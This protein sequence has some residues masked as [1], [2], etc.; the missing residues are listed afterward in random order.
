MPSVCQKIN[1]A[2]DNLSANE[3]RIQTQMMGRLVK[4]Q[5]ELQTRIYI[6]ME[7]EEDAVSEA[8]IE[9]L[10][11]RISDIMIQREA[12]NVTLNAQ[13]VT[14]VSAA[15]LSKYRKL[16]DLLHPDVFLHLDK[17]G[18][19]KLTM[20]QAL[21]FL[22]AVWNPEYQ[23]EVLPQVISLPKSHKTK[24]G[25]LSTCMCHICCDTSTLFEKAPCC[26]AFICEG[27]LGKTMD[28]AINGIAFHGVRCPF[29]QE[30]YT[31]A[32]IKWFLA[33]RF[34]MKYN[35]GHWRSPGNRKHGHKRLPSIY[36][37]NLH[38][39]FKAVTAC[40]ETIH[41]VRVLSRDVNGL[42]KLLG[43][44]HYYGTCTGCTPGVREFRIQNDFGHI[45]MCRVEKQCVNDENDLAVL[46]DDM[47]L[48]L[49]CKSFQEDYDDGTFKKCPHCAVRTVKPEG[50]NYVKC[51]DHRWCFVCNER[52]ENTHDGHNT[53]YYTGPGSGPYSNSC[54]KSLKLP[55]KPTFILE[56]CGCQSCLP[57]KG[58][59]LCRELECTNRTSSAHF[60][61]RY[62]A[63]CQNRESHVSEFYRGYHRE[64][65][66]V[67]H[68]GGYLNL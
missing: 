37:T 45:Q 43:S 48:C 5:E 56:K 19:D 41:A 63:E 62:C 46:R 36:S 24:A 65:E 58:E 32:Y 55:N 15:T 30:N 1:A 25:I 52:L 14:T 16:K 10:F 21:A 61:F 42:Q 54:R 53:H 20:G 64:P 27:C 26:G 66:L 40:L 12:L 28:T 6:A 8:L 44:D 33:S 67:D 9:S 51:G 59:A 35:S 34:T 50:C 2:C 17:K 29:C 3:R 23:V 7:M 68:Y 11:G 49:V 47:F 38:R 60:R 39:K 13:V 31:L 18:T 4:K 22:E 57:H